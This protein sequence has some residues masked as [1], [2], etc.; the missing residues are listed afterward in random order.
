[1]IK[2][3]IIVL[4][5]NIVFFICIGFK[6]QG[7]QEYQDFYIQDQSI[8]F[9]LHRYVL[10]HNV[11]DLRHKLQQYPDYINAADHNGYTLLQNAV[12]YAV[13]YVV[14]FNNMEIVD[15]LS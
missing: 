10:E 13:R 2:S 15:L 6:A 14:W 9:I 8:I 12:R 7:Q 5:L 11:E 4:Y 3:K 1:M